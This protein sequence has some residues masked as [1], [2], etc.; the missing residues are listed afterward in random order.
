MNLKE[1]GP[2]RCQ[3]A[4]I[5]CCGRRKYLRKVFLSE[6]PILFGKTTKVGGVYNTYT[7]KQ[8]FKGSLLPCAQCHWGSGLVHWRQS[9]EHVVSAACCGALLFLKTSDLSKL[10]GHSLF[11]VLCAGSGWKTN[12][13]S[14]RD[15]SLDFDHGE[16]RRPSLTCP[17]LMEAKGEVSCSQAPP[18]EDHPCEPLPAS[19][20]GHHRGPAALGES[21]RAP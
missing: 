17:S 18:R 4:F 2:L 7:Y 8:S 11:P 3:D 21:Q 12:I 5:I 13:S 20:E 10:Q 19:T 6:D 14:V 9:R 15:S 1:Q 16:W